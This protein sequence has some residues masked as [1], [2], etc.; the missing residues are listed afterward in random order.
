MINK[1][2]R[3]YLA[4][5]AAGRADDGI[6]ITLRDPQKIQML[7]NI[8]ADLLMRNGIDPRAITNEKQLINIINR[9]EAFEKKNL[10]DNIRSGIRNTE[11]AKVFDLEGK[12]IPRGSKIMGGKEV[13]G[14]SDR[15]RVR[16]E[17]KE[18]YGFTDERLDEIEK[19]PI[20]EEMADR[21]IAETD[22]PPPGSRGG[23][24]DIAAPVQSS[25]ETL[26]NM[27]VAENKKNIAKM[28]QRKMLEEAIDDASPGFSGD[29]K[30]DAEI[31]AE[32][33][34]ER[35]GMVYDDL[36]TKERIKLYDEAF[37]GLSKKKPGP[38][39]KADGGRIGFVKGTGFK[40][41]QKIFGKDKFKEM[42]TRD[43]EMYQGLLE[44]V[45]MYRKR[46]KEGLKMYLQKFLPHMDDAQIEDFIRGSDGS[47][48]LI[49][50]LIRLGSGRDYAGK[51]EMMKRAEN[52]RKLDDLE[53]TD[54]MIR[55]PNADGGIMRLG[56]KDGMNRR[57]FMKI[58]SGLVALPIIGKVLKPLKVGKTVTKVPIIKTDNVP[59]KPEWFDQLVNKVILEGDDV[60][61]RFATKER[62]IVH[63]KKLDE[64]TTVR[65]TQDMDQG[66]VRVE[67]QSPEN[68]YGE[69][70][71]LQYK[72][73]LPDEGDPRPSAEFATAESGP[74]S[75][76]VGPDDVELDVDEVG[77][78]SIKDLDSDVSK[79]KEYATGQKPTMKE[80]VQ[81]IK[82]KD[83][84][85]RIT[86][87]IDGAASDA[88]VR[89]QG[90]FDPSDYD[91]GMAS[92][93]LAGML[94]E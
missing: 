17:M 52:M 30:I 14:T 45:D 29:K 55:K 87:D 21:L 77:G 92:G 13:K 57:T 22:L 49:G 86:D 9:I 8:M 51:I 4:K 75:R 71:L 32:N 11:S 64:D 31:V 60:T 10:A 58:F 82:R 68:V 90:D 72:K 37:T 54:K 70:V 76:V 69:D 27:I 25:E 15:D 36:P 5:Q 93:G 63:M 59:G 28:R 83:K 91:D 33:L 62:E 7:E 26:K 6:M 41:L 38:E 3:N 67:Y 94:G 44:V 43:P 34:A 74:V 78:M 80:L 20:D 61:K 85:A 53:V 66:A 42:A 23:S 40:F 39:E 48:G 46:D 18:K 2:I 79:L 19:T 12:E 88:V 73:P 24:D 89:R 84:A 47:E 50:E 56:F 35:M 16:N 81:N 65:V 1:I